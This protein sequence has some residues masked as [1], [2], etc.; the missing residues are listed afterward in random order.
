MLSD[1]LTIL[2]TLNISVAYHHFNVATELP[3]V[4]YYETG[5]DNVFADNKVLKKVSNVDIELY[6]EYKDV[7]LEEKLEKALNDNEIPWQKI[8]ESYIDSE[9]MFESV[10]QI[11]L[12]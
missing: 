9:K 3:Y 10:Y 7:T 8:T 4:V 2:S 11:T 12:I 5:S 1:L 6:T